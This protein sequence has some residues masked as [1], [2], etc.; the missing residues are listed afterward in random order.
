[1]GLMELVFTVCITAHMSVCEETH[2]QFEGSASLNQ[3]ALAA[4]PYIAQ[5][6]GEHPKW[7]AVR[8]HCEYATGR[9]NKI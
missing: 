8:W 1:M 9:K 2:L 4:P 5:W 3:C 6:I 7:T